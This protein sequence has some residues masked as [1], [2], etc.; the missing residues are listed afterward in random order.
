MRTTLP[1]LPLD[2]TFHN[3]IHFYFDR[4]NE[5]C[6]SVK[7]SSHLSHL[8]ANFDV[9]VYWFCAV[10]KDAT[11][12]KTVMKNPLLLASSPC[13]NQTSSVRARLF[14]KKLFLG[15]C[16]SQSC[17]VFAH[18]ASAGAMIGQIDSLLR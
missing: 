17:F 18:N 6:D 16:L 4:C 15:L 14:L 7:C 12:K 11:E 5:P 9:I 1:L 2:F 13:S 10:K 3:R 8:A